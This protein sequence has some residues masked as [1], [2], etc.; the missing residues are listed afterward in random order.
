MNET[1]PKQ[2][3]YDRIGGRD[4]L[5]K[6]LQHF[7]ADVRQHAVIGPIFNQQIHDWPAH[8]EKIGSFWARLTGG[9]SV[10]SGQ[11][12]MKRLNLGIGTQHFG[13]WLQLWTFNCRS[14]F[15][16]AEAEEMICMAQEIG[17][18][19]KSI[20][21]VEPSPENFLNPKINLLKS[22][23]C[24]HDK[25]NP[26][27]FSIRRVYDEPATQDGLQFLVDGLWPR[28]VKKEALPMDGWLKEVAPSTPL[29]KWF[30]HEPA[31]WTEFRR[32]YRAELGKNPAAWKAL[33]AAVQK[34]NVTLL[35]AARDMEINQAVIL[36]KFLE[37]ELARR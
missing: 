37:E 16:E 20:L 29:R 15:A 7:Y 23:F 14:H 27:E 2:S 34:G 22:N 19:L 31:K 25:E 28:G 4:G 11:M 33:L 26:H 32:R 17:R 12:P 5:A 8:L 6:F 1:N 3:L 35:F 24:A 21:G 10:Y 36:K 18:R 30:G 13:A 9:P